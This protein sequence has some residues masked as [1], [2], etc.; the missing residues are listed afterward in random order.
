MKI[1][2]LIIAGLTALGSTLSGMADVPFRLH[3]FDSFK[4]TPVTSDQIVF[5][6]NSIT[7][8]HE[9]WE[10]FGCDQR[11]I[12]RGNSGGMSQEL[13]DNLESVLDG[14][15]AKLFLMIG[16]NDISTGIP[17]QTVVGNIRRIIERTQTES[18][19]TEI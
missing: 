8:M 17:Y 1:R 10:A 3:R 19:A 5:M 2:H 13:L 16:T 6:G 15:P 9:W 14:K 11:I 12:N 18:P 7:N 4:A